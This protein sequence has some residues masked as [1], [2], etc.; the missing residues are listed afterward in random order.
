MKADIVTIFP[1]F[2]RGPLDYGITRRAQELGLAKIEVHDLCGFTH[3]SRRTVDDRTFGG[4]EGMVL[5]PEPLFECLE[6]LAIAPR[7]ERVAGSGRESVVS[8]SAQGQ[9]FTQRI[10]AELAL[11]DRLVLLCGRHEGV[12]ERVADHLADHEL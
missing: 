4:G 12:D 9:R 5:K 10:A 7:E 1:D 2:F 3:D 8:L 11:L 6:S